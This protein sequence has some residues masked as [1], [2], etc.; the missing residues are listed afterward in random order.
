MSRV[1]P[2]PLPKPLISDLPTFACRLHAA[3][4]FQ[5]S[6]RMTRAFLHKQEVK[7][8]F[9]GSAV[10]VLLL[11]SSEFFTPT[12]YSVCFLYNSGTGMP[13]SID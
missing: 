1:Y 4:F 6:A 11:P 2:E 8:S 12:A 10:L 9:L 7:R 13:E 5:A 3:T